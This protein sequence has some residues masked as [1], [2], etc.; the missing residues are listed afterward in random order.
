[1]LFNLKDIQDLLVSEQENTSVR[2]LTDSDIIMVE[3]ILTK[4]TQYISS[5]NLSSLLKFVKM[6]KQD[7]LTRLL[8]HII[9]KHTEFSNIAD[10]VDNKDFKKWL[11]KAT[12][13]KDA[14]KGK[15]GKK[16]RRHQKT[17]NARALTF[18]L[19]TQEAYISIQNSSNITYNSKG[20]KNN[21]TSDLNMSAIESI[22]ATDIIGLFNFYLVMSILSYSYTTEFI[23]LG[24]SRGTIARNVLM[25]CRRHK[26]LCRFINQK[27]TLRIV[28]KNN[29][30]FF[31]SEQELSDFRI[32]YIFYTILLT[33]GIKKW[34]AVSRFY[35]NEKQIELSFLSG[36]FKF[37]L[38][39]EK[40]SEKDYIAFDSRVE[41]IIFR[42]LKQILPK[43]WKLMRESSPII[44]DKTI[45]VPDFGIEENEKV[46]FIEI[47]GFWREEYIKK[48]LAKLKETA[49]RNIPMILL[50]DEKIFNE[51]SEIDLPKLKYRVSTDSIFLDYKK[52]IK[53]V[54]ML[55]KK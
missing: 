9:L 38:P 18:S 46:V 10:S 11:G 52:L 22:S 33:P 29:D 39:L 50:V 45:I 35:I 23:I 20:E 37:I 42:T 19:N 25:F 3:N 40:R 44:L 34:R 49:K 21:N 16:Y 24:E 48:K 12:E 13:N 43:G 31:A 5:K 41:G 54:G 53:E 27:D 28:V 6:H 1:M 7:K 30:I 14:L 26:L 47:V 2:I 32:P 15:R 51:F 36:D 55:I 4:V 8:I 17:K